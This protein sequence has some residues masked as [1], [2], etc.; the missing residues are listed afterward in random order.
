MNQP[1]ITTDEQRLERLLE[2]G[3]FDNPI[4]RRIQVVEKEED[5]QGLTFQDE[6]VQAALLSFENMMEP[7][8]TELTLK[9]HNR[10]PKWD[11]LLE[12]GAAIDLFN[13][14]RC[15]CRD[16]PKPNE[17]TGSGSWPHSCYADEGYDR[18]HVV[19]FHVDDRRM[20]SQVRAIWKDILE[21]VLDRY[22][23]IGMLL[24][25]VDD[26]RQSDI[27]IS[28]RNLSG[29]TIGLAQFPNSRCH[30]DVFCYM[31]PGYLPRA[32]FD[33]ITKLFAHEIGHNMRVN[34]ISGDPIMHPSIRSGPFRSFVGTEFGRVL[35]R[36]FGGERVKDP[37]DKPPGPGPEPEGEQVRIEGQLKV[38]YQGPNRMITEGEELMTGI[39][40]PD[41]SFG[42]KTP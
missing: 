29:S 11:G 27:Q 5:L 20:P 10:E 7:E 42:A 31:D 34:H 9:H 6:V 35:G 4:V 25:E 17:A 8:F 13:E 22:A 1:V 37:N 40:V 3:H 2:L 39:V 24:I 30:D 14:D 26:I 33:Q 19:K 16:W 41:M 28:W 36:F 15:G 18:I 12:G 21:A 23:E 38:I 32:L